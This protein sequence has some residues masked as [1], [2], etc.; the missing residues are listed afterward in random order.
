MDIALTLV[1]NFRSAGVC[2]SWGAFL[3]GIY[4]CRFLLLIAKA[5]L[6]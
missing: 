2:S 6:L 4:L 5:Y 1:A 3:G